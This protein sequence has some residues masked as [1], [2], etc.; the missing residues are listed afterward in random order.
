LPER[1]GPPRLPCPRLPQT[2]LR[3]RPRKR[4]PSGCR[5]SRGQFQ[6]TRPSRCRTAN[7]PAFHPPNAR[8]PLC[9]GH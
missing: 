3:Q 2:H 6:E 5:L 4:H 1:W 9:R 8:R 7:R